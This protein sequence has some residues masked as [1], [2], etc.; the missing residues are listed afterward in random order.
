M[1]NICII[2]LPEGEEKEQEIGK[3]SEKRVKENFCNLVK[4]IDI[5]VQK[6]Q[7][8]KQDGWEEAHYKTHHH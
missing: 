4:E 3:L 7:S 6:A 8:P 1:S 2:G 5:Q